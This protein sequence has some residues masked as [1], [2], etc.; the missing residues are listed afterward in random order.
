MNSTAST[1]E[2]AASITPIK[3]TRCHKHKLMRI[4]A[5]TIITK[6]LIIR[7]DSFNPPTETINPAAGKH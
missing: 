2:H 6:I 3:P 5:I 7:F 1:A 4:R